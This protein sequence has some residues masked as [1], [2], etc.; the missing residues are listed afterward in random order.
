MKPLPK[1]VRLPGWVV[2][3]KVISRLDMAEKVGKSNDGCWVVEDKTIWIVDDLSLPAQ[4]YILGHEMDHM[5]NDWRHGLFLDGI[6]QH[7]IGSGLEN[8]GTG[9]A[10]GEVESGTPLSRGSVVSLPREPGATESFPG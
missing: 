3:I 1:Q 4:W 2:K 10:V 5:L 6:A 7:P 8:D 9:V